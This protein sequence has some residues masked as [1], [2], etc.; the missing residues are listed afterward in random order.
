MQKIVLATSAEKFLSSLPEGA[1][2]VMI[3]NEYIP[4]SQFARVRGNTVWLKPNKACSGLAGTQA[5]KRTGSK[6]ANR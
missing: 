3:G 6:P 2:G 4:F 1:T 5:K